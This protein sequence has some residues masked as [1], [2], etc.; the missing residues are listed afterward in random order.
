MLVR[1]ARL[2]AHIVN[3][4]PF[5]ALLDPAGAA[6]TSGL[7][8]HNLARESDAEIEAIV[9]D[10]VETLYH[11]ACTARMAPR[12]DGGVV[13]PLLRVHGVEGLRVCDASVFPTI[14][15]GHTVS[16]A[17]V[18]ARSETDELHRRSRRRSL[19]R[20]ELRIS[21]WRHTGS[22]AK[23]ANCGLVFVLLPQA[24]DLRCLCDIQRND[25]GGG[26]VDRKS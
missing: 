26:A 2:I 5:A 3:T 12:A 6:D 25:G 17:S 16:T 9:R 15:S 19:S 4:P 18:F 7:L 21:S 14:T 22:R 11:P 8:N 23:C 13:D 20:R 24:V 10:R 1:A